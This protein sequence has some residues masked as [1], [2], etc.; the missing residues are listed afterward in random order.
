MD[1]PDFGVFSL[2]PPLVTIVAAFL[3][4][5]VLLSLFL[6]CFVAATMLARFNPIVGLFN[7]FRDYVIAPLDPF[8]VSVLILILI[9]GGFTALLEKG[10]G[11]R[12]MAESAGKKVRT[13]KQGQISSWLASCA[14]F[15]T[16]ASP[17]IVGPVLKPF[18]D[19]LKIS[20]EKFSYIIDSTG[21]TIPGLHPMSSWGAFIV[22][23]IFVQ[24]N[25]L[26]YEGNPFMYFIASVPYQI[27]AWAAILMV[28]IVAVSGFDFG[29]MKRAER[30]AVEEGK[31][32]RD[33]AVLLRQEEEAAMP[34]GA[35][36]SIWI[37]VVPVIVLIVTIFAMF[38]YTG[39]FFTNPEVSFVGS[40]TRAA[41]L[42]SLIFSFFVAA[43][44]AAFM[45]VRAKAFSAR[46]T[47]AMWFE[48]V[49]GNVA[50]ALI[51]I[52]AY[53]IGAA[54]QA[55]GGPA[56]IV[57]VTEGYLTP[58]ALYIVV[59]IAAAITSFSTGTSWGTFAIFIPISVPLAVATGVPI[60]PAIGAAVSGGLFGDHCSPI[61]DTT[62]MASLGGGCD[63]MDHVSTQLPYA[64]VA[65]AAS[66]V[67]Y[68]FAGVTH[69]AIAGLGSMLVALTVFAFV[70][71]KF[72][73]SKAGALKR[74][75]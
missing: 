73:G 24:F 44:A 51:L 59:F 8:N 46:Q 12:A 35:R 2:L 32:F 17:L 28:V 57:S 54:S 53:G 19:R 27:Y 72:W 75:R 34:A 9:I 74:G 43:V 67:G 39:G 1:I 60:A 18:T 21:C 38:A 52:M 20:R 30:R 70:L 49:K 4:R 16:D 23:L 22:G 33:G 37:L 69:S 61:S 65:A 29:P 5:Q 58:A 63:I 47:A 25:A 6:G 48:G 40:F 36:I 11:A 68:F 10:G 13:R 3:T 31:L 14:I 7:T 45:I 41:A 50:I 64:L 26:G 71:N 66:V 62:I 15:F 56:F 42:P 55:V